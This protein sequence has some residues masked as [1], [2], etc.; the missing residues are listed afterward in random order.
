MGAGRSRKTDHGRTGHAAFYSFEEA[1]D[2]VLILSIR[3][4]REAGYWA[5]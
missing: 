2:A 3:H 4:Q 5:E 1:Q